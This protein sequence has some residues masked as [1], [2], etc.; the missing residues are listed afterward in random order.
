MRALPILALTL[1]AL[2]ACAPAA[3]GRPSAADNL[4]HAH[5]FMAANAGKPGVVNLP[6][7]LQ[8]RIIRSGPAA[9][10]SPKGA[11]RVAVIYEGKLTDGEVF[12]SSR[13]RP[14]GFALDGVIPAFTEALELM[15]PG[16]IWMIYAPPELAYGPDDSGPIPANSALIFKVELLAVLPPEG[17]QPAA[18]PGGPPTG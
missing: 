15:K 9:G 7:G 8:Y 16:D 1:L 11:D 3:P 13:G 14:T 2:A 18:P 12:D 5:A 6:T 10:V 17:A 4:A